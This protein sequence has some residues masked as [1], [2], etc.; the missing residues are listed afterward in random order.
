MMFHV[1]C[2]QNE[3]YGSDILDVALQEKADIKY[4]H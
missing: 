1:L 2:M 3:K 4:M